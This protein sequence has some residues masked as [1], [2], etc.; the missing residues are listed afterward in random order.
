MTASLP[1]ALAVR[2]GSVAVSLALAGRP[3]WCRRAAF[4]GSAIA[5]AAS[6][7]C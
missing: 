1:L 6:P 3:R 7:T 2:L 5:S 4:L